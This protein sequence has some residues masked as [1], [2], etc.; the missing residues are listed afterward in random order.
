LKPLFVAVSPI[1]FLN[2]AAGR[3]FI[4]KRRPD[5]LTHHASGLKASEM[6]AP[7][8]FAQ[9]VSAWFTRTGSAGW[10]ISVSRAHKN[11]Y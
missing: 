10:A 6:E 7:T 8:G 3:G 5:S 4:L 11:P 9:L 1:P 2:T